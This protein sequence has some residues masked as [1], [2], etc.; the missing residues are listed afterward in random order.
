MT[1]VVHLDSGCT[2]WL[3]SYIQT[4]V[5]HHDSSQYPDSGHTSRLRLHFPTP[6][7]H[8]DSSSTSWLRSYIPT[9]VDVMTPVIPPNSSRTSWLRLTS[10]LWSY[11]PTQV[12]RHDFSHTSWLRSHIMTSVAHHN[13]SPRSQLLSTS[14]LWS[15]ILTQSHIIVWWTASPGQARWLQ[16]LIVRPLSLKQI[17]FWVHDP[18]S[19]QNFSISRL[20]M[21]KCQAHGPCNQWTLS[22]AWSMRKLEHPKWFGTPYTSSR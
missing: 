12:A 9:L 10:W 13:S 11:I 17:E 8:P 19:A 1:L 21:F 15:Y 18:L 2:S 20:W 7:A 22:P 3:R 16:H 14:W 4:P 5:A 6:A